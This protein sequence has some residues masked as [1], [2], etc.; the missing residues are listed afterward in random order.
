MYVVITLDLDSDDP[1]VD[2]VTGPFTHYTD[3]TRVADEIAAEKGVT[4]GRES[5]V[6]PIH[7]PKE[8]D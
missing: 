1:G 7:G 5:H 6:V 8:A 4:R 2:T 3:A